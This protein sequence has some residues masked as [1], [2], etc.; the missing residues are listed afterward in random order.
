MED[1]KLI[2]K[3]REKLAAETDTLPS[4]QERVVIDVAQLEDWFIGTYGTGI[5]PESI[6]LTSMD[7]A[8]FRTWLLR[9]CKPATVQ[10]K[11]ASIRSMLKLLAPT[12]LTSL[13]MP[14]LPPTPK[15]ASSGWTRTQ[16]LAILRAVSRLDSARDRAI[17]ATALWAGARVSSIAEL[18]LSNVRLGARSGSVTFD[19]VKGGREART[20]TVPANVELREALAD[21]IHVR[22]PVKHDFLF[23]A[24]RYPFDPI[25]RWT[26]HDVWHR[27]LARHLP[28]ELAD[29][30]K[31]PHQTRH[32]LARL[33]LDQGVPLPD[34]AAILGH[35]SVATTANIYCRPSEQDLRGHLER[36]VGEEP[37]E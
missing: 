2:A 16:R 24:D 17:C 26:V 14:K 29:K 11:L 36:A 13:R 15:P 23:T 5:D 27:R 21:W 12:V 9:T 33:L 37:E 35:A 10:R 22:P 3:L 20:I 1:S 19:V 6:A 7:L 32:A 31:G 4:S 18:K 34:V 28:R 25:T 30:L 8:E